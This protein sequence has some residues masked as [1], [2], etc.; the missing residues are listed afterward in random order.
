MICGLDN[1]SITNIRLR[2]LITV[3][4]GRKR[5]RMEAHKAESTEAA[6]AEFFEEVELPGADTVT[7]GSAS[8][9]KMLGRIYA[10]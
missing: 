6:E 10:A 1:S 9:T 2:S 3:Y 5:A 8:Y 7:L 4:S